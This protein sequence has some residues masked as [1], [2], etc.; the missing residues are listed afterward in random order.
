MPATLSDPL[1]VLQLFLHTVAVFIIALILIRIAGRRSFG[2]KTPF[3]SCLVVLFGAILSR[4]AVDA[5]PFLPT[6]AI[7]LTIAVLHRLI[8]WLSVRYDR[9]ERWI[10]G[11]ERPLVVNGEIIER[12]M[13]RGLIT[14]R[15]LQEALRKSIG[16]ES[17]ETVALAL[18]ERDGKITV[19]Q[20]NS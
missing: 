13:R 15:D 12:N 11:V 8:A 2:Q 19:M 1:E 4:A 5:S 14:R 17:I 9:F 3:D 6:V 18:L 10:D 16:A 7:C 20:R